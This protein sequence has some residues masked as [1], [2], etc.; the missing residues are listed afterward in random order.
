MTFSSG[1]IK[2]AAMT[3]DHT[4]FWIRNFKISLPS[5]FL[6]AT[7]TFLSACSE[8]ETHAPVPPPEYHT[9]HRE[10]FK[11]AVFQFEHQG[12]HYLGCSIHQGGA[13]P[14]VKV[15]REGDS[16]PVIFRRRA[17]SQKDLHIWTYSQKSR[18]PDHVLTY[19]LNPKV[20]IGD[21][22][23]FLNKGQKIAATVVGLP[24]DGQF[25]CAYRTDAPFPAD[26][27]SGSPVYLPRTGT[28]IGVL[29]T[30]NHRTKAT[31]GGFELLKMN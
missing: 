20:E 26:G 5:R 9:L 11:G 30:A 21:R 31:L 2:I 7:F 18:K 29:Q 28:L 1:I 15:F 25:R 3:V 27:M 19:R 23:Y 13:S 16:E 4:A 8:E 10:G 17:H 24:D 22:I 12:D 6:L 14:G